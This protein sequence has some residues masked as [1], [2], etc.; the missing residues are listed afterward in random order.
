[1]IQP[2]YNDD[3][4]ITLLVSTAKLMQSFTFREHELGFQGANAFCLR[5]L[6]APEFFTLL[7]IFTGS[8][9]LKG[10]D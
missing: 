2:E 10:I 3:L 5:K 7:G 9:A 4:N 1:M 6:T 8:V